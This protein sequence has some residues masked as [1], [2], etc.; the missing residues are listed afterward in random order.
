MKQIMKI[1][2]VRTGMQGIAS[3]GLIDIEGRIT[4]IINSVISAGYVIFIFFAG[5]RFDSGKHFLFFRC[6]GLSFYP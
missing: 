2:P 1:L 4:I 3:V 6:R 5:L